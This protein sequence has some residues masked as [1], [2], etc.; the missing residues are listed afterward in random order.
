VAEICAC[1]K[2]AVFI[3]LP[4]AADNH[5]QK[6]AEVLAKADAAIMV[7][8]KDFNADSFQ[9]IIR[10]FRDNRSLLGQIEANVRRFQFPNAAEKIVE[11]LLTGALE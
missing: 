6:N 9:A 8:Q 1:E 5:Q 11:R 4:T 3:P 2:A 7:L 10:R